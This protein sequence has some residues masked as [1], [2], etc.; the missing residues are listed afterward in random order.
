MNQTHH[1][2][3]QY[4]DE[5]ELIDYLRVMWKWKWLII[6]GTLLCIL[7]VVIYSSTRPVI[8]MYKVSALIEIDHE[9]KLDP[10]VKIKSMIEYGIFNQQVLNDL[11][12]FE[13]IA[14]PQH[15]AFKV[16][17]PKKLDILDVSFK[18]RNPD[19]G[20]TVLNTLIKKL[21]QEY[22]ERIYQARYQFDETIKKKSEFIKDIEANIKLI[23]FENNNQM[24]QLTS[25]IRNIQANIEQIKLVKGNEISNLKSM[26]SLKAE[27]QIIEKEFEKNKRIK[28]NAIR[29]HTENIKRLRENIRVVKN[30]IDEIKR[31][32]KQAQSNSEKLAARR[33]SIMLDPQ[34]KASLEYV[35]V[36]AA[37]IQQVINYP[38]FL[39]DKIRSLSFKE[40]ELLKKIL[41][42]NHKIK[43]LEAH[44]QI[45][46]MQKNDSIRRE[47][48]NIKDLEAQIQT[49]EMKKDRSIQSEQNIIKDI[50]AKV[51]LI[52]LETNKSISVEEKKIA[53]LK[54]E[55]EG[56]KRDRDK[57]KGVIV[58]Q[59]PT[60][61]LLPIKYKA[62]R[63][64]TLAGIAGFFVSIFLAFFIEYI[65]SVSKPTKKTK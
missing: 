6:G 30:S 3:N 49:L 59:P 50:E 32:L 58:K 21:E 37:A 13:G 9:A 10:L 61:S 63:N 25:K 42:E 1:R 34:D 29:M 56:L 54:S 41:S 8:K 7:A 12:N 5:I 27:S 47:R 53:L 14:K 48:N 44:I 16:N 15:L 26:I 17:V 31:V 62:K 2:K 35:F 64:A 46:E 45:L 4:E 38:I 39:T 60:A 28:G 19:T 40:K 33:K 36:Q 51:S 65:T 57:I 55:I 43:D 24:A 23:K 11:T 52:E 20:K 22:K 18:A